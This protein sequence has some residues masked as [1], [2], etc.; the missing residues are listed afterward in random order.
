MTRKLLFLFAVLTLC[1]YALISSF[2][3]ERG[4]IVNNQ[5]KRQ[6][7]QNEYELDR[8]NVE[9][10]NLKL[11]EQEL[12]SREAALKGGMNL[13]YVDEGGEVYLLSST[14][15]ADVRTSDSAPAMQTAADDGFRPWKSWFILLISFA[16]S[17]I[18]CVS[19][20]LAG[21]RKGKTDDSQQEESG[22]TGNNSDLD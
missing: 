21:R 7:K 17:S 1:F 5:L 22:D 6:L 13:G 16:A 3:G 19:V 8:Q 4:F 10:E 14:E 15:P 9:L 11:Q 2:A 12:D 20:R 18:I